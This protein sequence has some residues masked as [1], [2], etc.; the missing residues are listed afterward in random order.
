MTNRDPET[1][2]LHLKGD[3]G[4]VFSELESILNSRNDQTKVKL[5]RAKNS[6]MAS[7]SQLKSS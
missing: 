6:T 3:R 2:L 4:F 5:E 1:P 7:E